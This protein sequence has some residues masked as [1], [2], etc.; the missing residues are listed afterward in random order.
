LVKSK[1]LGFR[2]GKIK[3]PGFWVANLPYKTTYKKP[4]FSSLGIQKT[5]F[6]DFKVSSAIGTKT[7]VFGLVK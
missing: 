1:N 7:W 4:G 6:F 2:V 3:K 5:R